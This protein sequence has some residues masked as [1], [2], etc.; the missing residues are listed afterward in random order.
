ML[1]QRVLTAILLIPPAVAAVWLLPGWAFALLIAAML[2]LAAWE[3]SALMQMQALLPRVLYV[4]LAGL[5]LLASY[6][7]R[8]DAAMLR[9]ILVTAAVWWCAA[10]VWVLNYPAGLE[11]GRRRLPL[12]ALVGLL[13]LAPAFLSLVVLHARAGQG[14]VW[15]LFLLVLIWAADT[16]A[17]FSG[18]SFGRHKMAVSVSPGKTWEGAAG[19]FLLSTIAAVGAGLWLFQL[20]G[21]TLWLFVV[22]CLSVTVFSVVG[23]LTESMFKRHVGVKDSG[24]LFPGHGGVLDRLDSL[25]AAAPLFLCGL[26]ALGL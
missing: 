3:W 9:G 16:G 14:P 1:K 11:P 2:L 17:Y 23:D 12:K 4:L 21:R 8:E 25:F 24:A 7:W 15:I 5:A 10:L 20:Q 18:R 22:M 13:L 26:I 6:A 19:G